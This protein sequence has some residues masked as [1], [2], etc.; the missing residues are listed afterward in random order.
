VTFFA[1]QA[2][3]TNGRLQRGV[4]EAAAASHLRDELLRES[5]TPLKI[6]RGWS[7]LGRDRAGG[8][9]DALAA[10]LASDLG[11]F[12]RSGLSIVQALA[13]IESAGGYSRLVGAARRV[14]ERVTAG[15]P[16]SEAL[17]SIR[18]ETG[19]LLQSL[20]RAGEMTG[21][22]AEILEAGAAGLKAT[23]RLK[24]RVLTLTIYPAFVLVMTLGAMAVFALAV[25]PA[26]EPAF[27]GLG[28]KLPQQTRVVLAASRVFRAALPTSLALLA[29]AALSIVV[30]PQLRRSMRNLLEL[31]ALSPVAG[32]VVRDMVFSGLARRLSIALAAGSP[33]LAAFAVSADAVSLV[34]IQ[35]ALLSRQPALR[36]GMQLSDLLAELSQTP[37]VLVRLVRVGET[38]GHLPKLLGEA[39]DTL[40]TRAQERIERILAVMTPVLVVFIGALVALIMICVFQGLLSITEAVEL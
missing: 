24:Q 38:S 29:V 1:Y 2:L 28:E 17:A 36:D 40:S 14:R 15:E 27:A 31:V 4:R 11:R 12:I 8:L 39:A 5:L 21:R 6:R 22:L 16:L 10:E 9:S 26:L 34:M 33:L 20:A 37:E 13:V 18:G 25:I 7:P 3:D 30:I 23:A 35:K 19:R 32:G